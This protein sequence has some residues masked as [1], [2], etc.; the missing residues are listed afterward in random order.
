MRDRKPQQSTL[1]IRISESLRDYLEGV[2]L[3]LSNG[4]SEE[5]STSDVVKF[6]LESVMGDRLDHR[7]EAADLHRDVTKSLSV[8]RQKLDSDRDLKHAEWLLLAQFV[9]FGCEEP[10]P[11][12][13]L[14]SAESLAPTI[15]AFL[16]VRA[17]R[18]D[19][20]LGLDRYYLGN[21]ACCVNARQIG[22]ELVPE[23][24]EKL[25]EQL[26][27]NVSP[28][29]RPIFAG[30]NL[31]VALSDERL[32]GL[33]VLNQTLKPFLGALFRVAARGHWLRKG[34]PIVREPGMPQGSLSL[35]TLEV[36]DTR[37]GVLVNAG[38]LHI[39]ITSDAKT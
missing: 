3:V 22:P 31:Y 6:L 7:F 10:C 37:I 5:L 39:T 34:Q 28:G 13:E 26:R 36:D 19:N 17:L 38:E 24:A 21:L 8:I 30:R 12:P 2:R 32:P 33:A 29:N 14:P 27:R 1:S 20:G 11:N 15:L 4:G 35:P 18:S 16:A 23:V 9:Q 25:V